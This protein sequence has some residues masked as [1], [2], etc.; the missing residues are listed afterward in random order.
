MRG[1]VCLISLVTFIAQQM[2]CCCDLT[3]MH[4]V[5]SADVQAEIAVPVQAASSKSH[6]CGHNTSSRARSRCQSETTRQSA[7]QQNNIAQQSNSQE[8]V[9]TSEEPH[10]HHLCVG[11]H[12]FYNSPDVT[13]TLDLL[14]GC[15]F[16]D[17]GELV[18]SLENQCESFSSLSLLDW[19]T[20]P[21]RS[22][23]SVYLV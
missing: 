8:P 15:T 17:A 16:I 10:Q 13:R 4:Q 5:R 20:H 7:S 3:G 18:L 23:L 1:A 2:I 6:C 12:L 21:P 9:E 14:T 22:V 19:L 11:T